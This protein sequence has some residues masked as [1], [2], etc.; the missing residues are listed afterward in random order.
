MKQNIH[1]KYNKLAN[2]KCACGATFAAGST[3]ENI[4]VEICSQCHPFY[5]GKQELVD[6]AGRVDKFKARL[7][8]SQKLKAEAAKKTKTPRTKKE[9]E[10]EPTDKKDK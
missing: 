7:E 6:T 8:A 5:T 4:S 1:P 2:I 10:E 9:V 3:D